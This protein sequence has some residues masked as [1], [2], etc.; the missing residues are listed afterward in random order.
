M[1]SRPAEGFYR[2]GTLI[3]EYALESEDKVFGTTM[4]QY[5][6]ISSLQSFDSPGQLRNFLRRF[7]KQRA[8]GKLKL[9][10]VNLN[11]DQATLEQWLGL[12]GF[13]ESDIAAFDAIVRQADLVAEAEA[14][15][16]AS[17]RVSAKRVRKSENIFDE[18]IKPIAYRQI[19]ETDSDF[20]PETAHDVVF[21]DSTLS[22]WVLN[23]E[24]ALVMTMND[25]AS[26]A[27][28]VYLSLRLFDDASADEIENRDSFIN[29]VTIAGKSEAPSTA[30]VDDFIRSRGE[31]VG[32]TL[33]ELKRFARDRRQDLSG[34]DV[35]A[36]EFQAPAAELGADAIND[37]KRYQIARKSV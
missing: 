7:Q 9:V 8:E 34:R 5:F 2:E 37:F 11:E 22:S 25:E 16:E 13:S 24:K 36:L 14:K 17:E 3:E 6:D 20:N 23:A 12:L 29:R 27:N 15:A 33:G 26:L 21:G 10:L 35:A 1:P 28:M 30:L 31:I 19:A 4:V 18:L 32:A